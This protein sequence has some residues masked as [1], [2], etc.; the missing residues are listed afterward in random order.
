MLQAASIFTQ[1]N[2]E[3]WNK[4]EMFNIMYDVA[5]T[6]LQIL[7]SDLFQQITTTNKSEF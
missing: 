6:S 5:K 4:Q 2:G 1:G 7:A 3:C